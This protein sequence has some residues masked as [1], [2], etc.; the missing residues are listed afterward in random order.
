MG[1]QLGNRIKLTNISEFTKIF[2]LTKL[3]RLTKMLKEKNKIFQTLF[4]IMKV[5]TST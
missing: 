2:R 4:N 3:L 1:E 5:K